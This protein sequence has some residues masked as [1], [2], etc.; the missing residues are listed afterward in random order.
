MTEWIFSVFA[1]CVFATILCKVLDH[2]SKEFSIYIAVSVIIIVS[3]FVF[4][5]ISPVS[6]LV[7]ELFTRAGLSNDFII[8]LFKSVG[9]CYIT[10]LSSEV[11]KDNGQGAI[12]VIAEL[13]GKVALIIVSMPL[14]KSI[15]EIITNLSAY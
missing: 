12:S 14:T 3:G 2:Y 7:E 13:S 9:I 5:T 11:C 6:E 8:I 10:E 15:I 1:L 4:L